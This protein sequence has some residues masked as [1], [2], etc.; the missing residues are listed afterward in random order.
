[1][2]DADKIFEA[3]RQDPDN[4]DFT[5]QGWDPLYHI[6]PEATI[7]IASQAPGRKAQTTKTYWNDPSGDRLRTWMGVTKDQF[8]H[9]GKI[10]V[11]PLD[12]YYPGKWHPSLL[13]LMP[14]IQLTI[15][16][17]AY[18]QK[19]YLRKRREKTLTATVKNFRAYLPDYF[20]IVHPSPLNY[21][22]VN[23]NP[24]FMTDV[25][26]ALQAQVADLMK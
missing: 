6:E 16:I 3:I 15:V 25:V 4:A 7:L 9:S 2:T 21:G 5:A 20:P 19:Y 8:Y 14:K 17:G 22:W 11:L 23:R 18:A 26:P 24:W 1:M 10:A 12:F 13:A